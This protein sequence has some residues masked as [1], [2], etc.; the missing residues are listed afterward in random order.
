MHKASLQ[1]KDNEKENKCKLVQLMKSA[2][3]E[4]V[5]VIVC[6]SHRKER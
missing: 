2:G 1:L 4:S 5:E 6:V 3:S